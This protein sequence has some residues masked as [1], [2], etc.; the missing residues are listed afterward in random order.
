MPKFEPKVIQDLNPDIL[1]DSV[2]G[3]ICP[4][5]WMHYLVCGSHFAT[6]GANG[7]WLYEKW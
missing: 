2:V 7:R 4:K 1:I 5:M 6:Y 3:Q